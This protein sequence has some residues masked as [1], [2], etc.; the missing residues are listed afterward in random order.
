MQAH[1]FIPPLVY[2]IPTS[3]MV[4]KPGKHV[5]VKG[6]VYMPYLTQW[7]HPQYDIY[8]MI[9]MMCMIFSDSPPVYSRTAPQV[10]QPQQPPQQ[11]PYPGGYPYQGGY[12]NQ[13][14]GYPTSGSMAMPMP[15]GYQP[16]PVAQTPNPA[17]S[18]S[19]YPTT[20]TTPYTHGD[21]YRMPVIGQ[22][23]GQAAGGQTP[24]RHGSVIDDK[25]IRMSLLSAVEDKL[26]RRIGEVFAMGKQ[27]VDGLEVTKKKLEDGA[28]TLEDITNKIK[29][30]QGDIQ[31]NINI[32]KQKN[33]DIEEAIKQ[34][35]DDAQNLSIDDAVQTTAPLYNQILQLYAEESA[36]EDAIYYLNDALRRDVLKIDV[37]L[38][39]VRNLST[40]Q[41]MVRATL[42]KAR[43]I[44]GLKN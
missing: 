28:C 24:Q 16:P 22:P 2:V 17:S 38:K 34:I 33:M 3:A 21:G 15:G 37:F 26:K 19:P 44:A 4:I 31:N 12:P 29:I 7:K 42:Q 14:P 27:E 13:Q 11:Q 20:N 5:D 41:F 30:E 23:L 9:N 40:K 8:E 43:K 39:N 1:P 10:S 35:E 32:L 25:M 6:R 18:A 36:I